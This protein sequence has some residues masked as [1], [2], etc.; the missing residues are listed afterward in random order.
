MADFALWATACERAFCSAGGFLHAYKANRRSAIEEVVDADPV[1]A[2]I[3]DIMTE[4]T[5]WSGNASE[6]LRVSAH[7][8]KDEASWPDI[9]WPKSPRALAGRLR[10][11]QTPLRALGIEM[12]F[13]REGR[14]GTRIIRLRASPTKPTRTTVSTVS[15]VSKALD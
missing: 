6:L 9:G 13:S 4:R 15:T 10:R 7:R 5:M 2:R 3:R 8:S 1:A 11:A 14:A 12:N